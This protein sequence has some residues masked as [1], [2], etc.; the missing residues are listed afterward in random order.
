MSRTCGVEEASRKLDRAAV[1]VWRLADG[2]HVRTLAGHSDYVLSVA[3]SPDGATLFVA[4]RYNN[5]IRAIVIATRAVT[6]LAGS[7]STGSTNANGTSASFNSP[8]SSMP[9]GY[10]YLVM[11]CTSTGTGVCHAIT[12]NS[13]N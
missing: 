9:P 6:T 3:V 10:M 2:V 7:G 13:Q 12:A 4:D 1:R 11:L 5:R 8:A